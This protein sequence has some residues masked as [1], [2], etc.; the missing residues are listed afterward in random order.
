MLK[1]DSLYNVTGTKVPLKVADFEAMKN[2]G[3]LYWQTHS[4]EASLREK[5]RDALGTSCGSTGS[6]GVSR[7]LM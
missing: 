2:V 6:G 5:Q 1:K 3:V 7:D 4:A